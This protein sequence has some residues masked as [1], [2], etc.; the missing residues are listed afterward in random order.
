LRRAAESV[1]S[2]TSGIS[3]R[4]RRSSRTLVAV[5]SLTPT[6]FAILRS[7]AVGSSSM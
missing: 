3:P 1:R 2:E 7:L 4:R 6:F 5:L